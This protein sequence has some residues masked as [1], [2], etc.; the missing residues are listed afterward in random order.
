MKKPLSNWFGVKLRNPSDASSLY[1]CLSLT[2]KSQFPHIPGVRLDSIKSLQLD[3]SFYTS[4]ARLCAPFYLLTML[5]VC[6]NRKK[7][8]LFYFNI[9]KC[10]SPMVLLEFQCPTTQVPS[11]FPLCILLQGYKPTK[12]MTE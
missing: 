4:H 7:P 1:I 10:V 8:L 11:P 3:R 9:M 12:Q 6:C 5:Y 2:N